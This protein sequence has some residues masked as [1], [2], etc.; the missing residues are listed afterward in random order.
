MA[1]DRNA[2]Q[3][4]AGELDELVKPLRVVITDPS[5]PHHLV[6]FL[7]SAGWTLPGL[8]EADLTELF[9]GLSE[10]ADAIAA[11][12]DSISTDGL[13][14]I[15]TSLTAIGDAIGDVRGLVSSFEDFVKAVLG[16]S[17]HLAADLVEDVWQTLLMRWLA[18]R[19]PSTFRILRAVGVVTND[20]AL[21]LSSDAG[22][23]VRANANVLRLRPANLPALI[24]DPI[25]TLR[26]IYAA[27][28]MTSPID[29]QATALLVGSLTR[30]LIDSL[31]GQLGVFPPWGWQKELP[32]GERDRAARSIVL[33]VPL[34][35]PEASAFRPAI[36]LVTEMLSASDRGEL[37]RNGP[38]AEISLQGLASMNATKGSVEL[39]LDVTA[40]AGT[41]FVS[42]STVVAEAGGAV[43]ATAT[44]SR[45]SDSPMVL[46][47]DNGTR[48]EF[49]TPTMRTRVLLDGELDV[50]VELLL[51]GAALVVSVGDGDSFLAGVLPDVSMRVEGDIGLVWSCQRGLRMSGSTDLTVRLPV[52]V[53]ILSLL[54]IDVLQS[55][56]AV[57]D[58]GFTITLVIDGEFSLGPFTARVEGVGMRVLIEVDTSDGNIGIGD[59]SV[60]FQPPYGFEFEILIGETI[61][62]G[63]FVRYDPV[64]ERYSGALGVQILAVELGAIV[65]VDT[66]LPG[67]PDGWAL[68]ASL[69]LTF[70]SIP[71]SFG[72]FLSG[73][74]GIV[75]INRSMDALAI[76]AGLREGAVDAILFPPD[77]VK[78]AAYIIS[79]LDN[80]FPLCAGSTVFGIAA[81][82]TWGAPKTIITAQIGAMIVLPE[83]QIAVMGSV[84]LL[85][86]NEDDPLLEL[87]MDTI[88]TYDSTDRTLMIVASLY[89]ST[90]L[91]TIDLSGDMAMYAR[92]GDAPYFLLSIGGYNPEFKPPAGLPD[93]VLDLRRIRAEVSLSDDVWYA[94]ET[95]V[96][97][98][99]NAFQFGA[100]ATLEAS[101]KFLTVTY[102]ARGY[103]G[104]DVLL[105]FSPFSFVATFAAGVT[106]TAGSSD[107]EL[108]AV[109][110]SARLEGPDPW[111]ASGTARFRFLGIN[112]SFEFAVG[113]SAGVEAKP[114]VNVLDLVIEALESVTSWSAALPATSALTMASE[115]PPADDSAPRAPLRVRP[116]ADVVVVQHV[117]PLDRPMDIYGVNAIEGETRLY[118]EQAAITGLSG[119]T[120]T[121]VNDWFAPAEFD[122]MTKA[123]RLSS[124]SYEAMVGGVRIS[125]GGVSFGDDVQ[126]VTPDYEV[127]VVSE[128]DEPSRGIGLRGQISARAILDAGSAMEPSRISRGARTMTSTKFA[129]AEVEWVVANGN[130]GLATGSA[131]SYRQGLQRL[132]NRR[133]DAVDRNGFMLVPAHAARST[134]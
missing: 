88:G 96:A 120:F 32:A 39:D 121:T 20:V 114:R 110:L 97:V 68:F 84:A 108:L 61:I 116:D 105:N 2:L 35:S 90:L 62:G 133:N 44:I 41:V 70:P 57:T 128:I 69:F 25:G 9:A 126:T 27:T 18:T 31:G 107:N 38:G 64:L 16:G 59:L 11:L 123:E 14:D 42:P 99:S 72:F 98:A 34:L 5:P 40:T 58:S 65:V 4:I 94:L 85:L 37:G 101:V 12:P 33:E 48:L 103:I 28:P 91:G 78:D 134:A 111:A 10:A 118:I 60:E 82:I 77:P 30:P 124:P 43:D 17:E 92:L 23:Q 49:G 53:N 75:C 130:T 19:R 79:Q 80:W 104:F 131:G 89:D 76:A 46:G 36:S 3:A 56:L 26:E 73:V 86:P 45:R 6:R 122:S 1:N 8:A 55:T 71:L 74:G 93:V 24:S 87:H 102:T 7:R 112:V 125:A 63:G 52:D 67:D 83:L 106:I 81:T 113:G 21:P 117:A 132:D 100:L 109:E 119:S 115:T 22:L 95:Y 15:A 13:G 66:K 50:E 29:A 51:A 47:A 129:V 127:K 54:V